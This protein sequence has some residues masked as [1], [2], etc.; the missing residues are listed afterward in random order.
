M[1]ALPLRDTPSH[2]TRRDYRLR[3]PERLENL[4]ERIPDDVE[5]SNLQIVWWYDETPPGGKQAGHKEHIPCSCCKQR[6]RHW[7]GCVVQLPDGRYAL[8]GNTCGSRELGS[9]YQSMRNA[10]KAKVDLSHGLARI[11]RMRSHI[12]AAGAELDALLTS[13]AVLDFDRYFHDLRHHFGR[14]GQHLV[15]TVRSNQGLLMAFEKVFDPEATERAAIDVAE[16]THKVHLFEA[17]EKASTIKERRAAIARWR[18]FVERQPKQYKKRPLMLG[19]CAGW[20]VLLA[21]Q[22]STPQK[23][24]SEAI[25]LFAPHALHIVS[26][27][28][29]EWTNIELSKLSKE[30][31]AAFDKIDNA[32]E[33]VDELATFCTEANINRVAA[34]ANQVEAIE[35]KIG[36]AISTDG[37]ALCNEADARLELPQTFRWPELPGLSAL[38]RSMEATGDERAWARY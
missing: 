23:L 11:E 29:H 3:H 1:I 9:A 37:A 17:I 6:R 24:V 35:G 2:E 33:L 13:S 31:K 12:E 26:R 8:I 22:R 5:V 34:W 25:G 36:E 30:L 28:P 18:K 16:Q 21:N 4:A 32:R 10:F 27:A 14:L 7:I 19:E 38:R 20:R 15:A